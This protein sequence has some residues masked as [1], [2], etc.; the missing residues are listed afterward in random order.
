MLKLRHSLL[1]TILC[2]TLFLGCA[3]A[4]TNLTE[5]LDSITNPN[6]TPFN[7]TVVITW[8]GYAG[9]GVSPI[10]G[11][12]STARVYNG[13]LSVLLV[14]T[15]TAAPGT[16]Y[17][18][19]YTSSDGTVTWSEIWQVPPSATPLTLSQVRQ[20]GGT[21]SGGTG[22]GGQF[23][24]LPISINDV[25]SLSADLSTIN[26]SLTSLTSQI[27]ALSPVVSG[28]SA[29]LT[30]LT[31]TV[32]NLTNTVNG[33]IST[34]NS[35]T[36]S[37]SDAVFVDAEDPAGTID[38]TNETFTLAH[39]PA[40]SASLSLYLNGLEKTSGVDFTLNGASIT[41][42]ASSTPELGDVMEAY[43]R[44]AGTGAAGAFADAEVPSGTINGTNLAFTLGAAPSPAA[45]LKLY[46]NG[47]LLTQNGDYTL[48]GSAITFS[49]ASSTPQVGDILSA[50]YRH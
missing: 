49:G 32:T 10:T 27:N 33:L 12:S 8:N 6:G 7:G 30:D 20:S 39:A 31:S 43:Y 21:S 23:A 9:S 46:K 3:P 42:S 50:S 24:T 35:L 34:V 19:V 26:S 4:Q 1:A 38:G 41:F 25:T 37:G 47:V 13:A 22:S 48:S 16:Y 36:A 15:T 28:N 40:P 17:Q 2:T 11:L 44:I 45:S 18:V 5:V 29:S 14:P